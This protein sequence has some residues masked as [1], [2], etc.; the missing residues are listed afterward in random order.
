MLTIKLAKIGKKNYPVFKLIISEKTK[1][2]QGDYLELLG[3]YNPHT[4]K[5]NL[6]TDRIK[7]WLSK[8]AKTTN[9]IHNLLVEQKVISAKKIKFV[10]VKKGVEEKAEAKPQE[11]TE[12]KPS[13]QP[14]KPE[15]K[16]KEREGKPTGA[17]EQPPK[18]TGEA[19]KK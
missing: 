2:T 13:E 8:G 15:D 11:K 19:E 5:I 17:T 7:Y 12:E 4:N 3:D 18:I 10:K 16:S 6:K 1:D 9:T 14:A